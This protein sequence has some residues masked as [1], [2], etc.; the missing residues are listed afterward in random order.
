VLVEDRPLLAE[1]SLD[2]QR[3]HPA[4][5]PNPFDPIHVHPANVAAY[6]LGYNGTARKVLKAWPV[7][8]A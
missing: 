2:E 4:S 1:H 5:K 7:A 6:R 3:G 8:N